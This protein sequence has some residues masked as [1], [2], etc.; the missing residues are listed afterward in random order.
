M[1]ESPDFPNILYTIYDYFYNNFI[2]ENS[3]FPNYLWNCLNNV[4]LDVPKTNNAI[5]AWHNVFSS[6]FG[7]AKFSFILLIKKL[8]D[9]EEIIKQSLLRLDTGEIF[10]RKRKYVEMENNLKDF[11]MV[12]NQKFG[13]EYV[14]S[15]IQLLF[16]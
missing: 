14:M 9:E 6:S 8:R 13:V 2:S 15:L 3:N 5:E 16:Y 10:T 11:I 1:K 4:Y 12:S 7:T